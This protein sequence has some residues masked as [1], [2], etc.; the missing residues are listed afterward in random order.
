MGL[1]K[2]IL[3]LVVLLPA[4]QAADNQQSHN[5]ANPHNPHLQVLVNADQADRQG[6]LDD[7]LWK[8]ISLRDEQRRVAVRAELAAGRVKSALDFYN[9]AL[10]MQHGPTLEDI[11]MAHAMATL[12]SELD[13]LDRSARWLKA[14][15]WDRMMTTQKKPQWYGTQYTRDADG[16]WAL[17][18]LDESAV[19][20][21]QRIELAAPTLAEARK[22]VENM[23][24]AGP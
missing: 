2:F 15:S 22:R 19:T 21:E 11:R 10:V 14:A 16:T 20:D 18:P 23:N 4:C 1:K 7:A 6:P 12:A 13:P 17:L 3:A 24:S 5:L 9:A 8:E